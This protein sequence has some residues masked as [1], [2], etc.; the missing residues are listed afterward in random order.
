[1]QALEVNDRATK[2]NFPDQYLPFLQTTSKWSPYLQIY[3]PKTTVS[4]VWARSGTFG[5]SDMLFLRGL[6]TSTYPGIDILPSSLISH[7]LC[8]ERKGLVSLKLPSCHQ[9]TQLSTIAVRCWHLLNT[10]RNYTPWQR[11]RSTKSTDLIG[12]IKFL[13]WWQLDGCSVTRP[14]L[15]LWRVWLAR[16]FAF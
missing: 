5:C 12:R 1:M 8:R 7:T 3:S 11:M 16:L 6:T 15:S 4:G 9:G 10:W 13:S 2:H 14:F